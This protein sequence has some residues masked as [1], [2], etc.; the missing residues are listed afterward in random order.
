MKQNADGYYSKSFFIDLPNGQKKQIKVRG[1][2]PEEVQEKFLRKKIE[3]ENGLLVINNNTLFSKW[4]DNWLE[5]YK[6]PKVTSSTYNDIKSMMD[7]CFLQDLGSMK[8]CDIRLIH[9]QKCLNKLEG[10]SKSY[11]HQAQTYIKA[12]FNKAY[13]NELIN[14]SPCIGLET[15]TA[16]AKTDRRALTEKELSFFHQAIKTHHRGAFFG[17]ML[18]CGLRPAEARALTW[19]NINMKEKTLSVRQSIQANSSE[20]KEPKTEAGKRTIPIP[21]WYFNEYL[22]KI[23]RTDSPY[24]FPGDKGQPLAKRR[25]RMGWSSLMRE[26]DLLAGAQTYRNKIIVHSPDIGQDLTPYNLRHTYATQL[27]EKG[28]PLKTAQY[29]LGHTDIKVTSNIYTHVTDKM[30]DEARQRLNAQ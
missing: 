19:F 15:P 4:V 3:A 7:R 6:K 12:C 16:A 13:E 29:L 5:T 28:V 21:D 22:S 26:M 9:V 24:I 25:Y 27:A 20:V 14:R 10:K 17:I 2:S 30:I 1:K 18:A 11:I 23:E 8:I